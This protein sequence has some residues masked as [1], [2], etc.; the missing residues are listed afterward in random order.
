MV[1]ASYEKA[2]NQ[3]L[4]AVFTYEKYSV[5]AIN[6]SQAPLIGWH[7]PVNIHCDW[8][9]VLPNKFRKINRKINFLYI[10]KM[11]KLKKMVIY[12]LFIGEK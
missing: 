1:S 2:S 7:R 8:L 10:K 11:S 12:I 4:K 3:T 6:P 9:R 5:L